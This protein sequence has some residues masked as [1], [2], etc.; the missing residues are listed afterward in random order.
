MNEKE[1]KMR[2]KLEEQFDLLHEESKRCEPE[3]LEVLTNSML[4]I[5]SVLYSY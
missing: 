4:S 1:I 2:E 3:Y 5:Y